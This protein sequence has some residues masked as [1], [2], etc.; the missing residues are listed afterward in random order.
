MEEW[1]GSEKGGGR[2]HEK[3]LPR[4][5]LFVF[6]IHYAT[7][8]PWGQAQATFYRKIKKAKKDGLVI[9]AGVLAHA[10]SAPSLGYW[11]T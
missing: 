11:P 10:P 8:P 4:K 5:G 6:Y 2:E 7:P 3:F 9:G 1:K